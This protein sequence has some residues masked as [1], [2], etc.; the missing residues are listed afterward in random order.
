MRFLRAQLRS[1]T[2]RRQ[3]QRATRRKFGNFSRRDRPSSHPP[4]GLSAADRPHLD[5]KGGC[6][7]Y[8]LRARYRNH[9]LQ[10]LD[11]DR[12]RLIFVLDYEGKAYIVSGYMS[13]RIGRVWKKWPKAE[14]DGR[15]VVRID[16]ERY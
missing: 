1:S 4:L 16:G 3:R 15:A 12:S 13:N 8:P 6:L 10:L 14:R 7:H 9:R 2:A 5:Q 11:P